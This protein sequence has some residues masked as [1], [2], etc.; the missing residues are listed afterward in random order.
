M[1]AQDDVRFGVPVIE[2]PEAGFREAIF[3]RVDLNTPDWNKAWH[4]D[5]KAVRE[6]ATLVGTKALVAR[7]RAEVAQSFALP[8]GDKVTVT[9]RLAS[10]D[11][12][13]EM[14]AIV[15]KAPVA[16]PHAIYLP[17]PTAL[18]DGWNCHFETGGAVLE[19]DR[20]QLPYASRHY[21]TTQRF[22]RIADGQHEV[23]RRHARRA[24]VAGGRVH[25]RPPPG[26]RRSA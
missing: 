16:A 8:G 2:R 1:P 13:L 15:D 23:T 22:I 12:A 5:W 7:G 11:E 10:G 9:Y 25:L 17:I 6:T 20:E 18:G 19:L 3:D 24:A 14:T 4:T 21:I 26:A